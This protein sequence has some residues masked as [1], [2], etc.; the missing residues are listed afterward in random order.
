MKSLCATATLLCALLILSGINVLYVNRTANEMKEM[1][2]NLPTPNDVA[3]ISKT[4][5]LQR[6]WEKKR[7]VIELSASYPIIDRINEQAA[8]LDAC[9]RVGDTYGFES[10]KTLLYDAIEDMCRAEHISIEN[11]F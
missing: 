1:I 3:C 10:A 11:L 4:E 7:R 8:L 9:A 6:L 5:R 2:N